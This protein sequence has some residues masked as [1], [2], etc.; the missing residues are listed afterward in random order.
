MTAADFTDNLPAP[1]L[2]AW[3][4]WSDFIDKHLMHLSK[5]RIE[6]K[7][8]WT[9]APNK[10]F[11]DEFQQAWACFYRHLKP[12]L[13]PLLRGELAKMESQFHGVGLIPKP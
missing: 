4:L 7:I 10:L 11:L 3:N 5:Q 2:P 9:G 13:E 8:P 12:N 1:S 6:N